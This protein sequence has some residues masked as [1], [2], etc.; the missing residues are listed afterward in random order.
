MASMFPGAVEPAANL[1][2]KYYNTYESVNTGDNSG[3]LAR[4]F[5]TGADVFGVVFNATAATVTVDLDQRVSSFEPADICI[6]NNNGRSGRDPNPV[7]RRHPHPG[8]RPGGS[9]AHLHA[10]GLKRS[11]DAGGR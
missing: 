5:T 4:G 2:G 1:T 9:C 8:G 11:G 7:S 10:L 3:A 6:L